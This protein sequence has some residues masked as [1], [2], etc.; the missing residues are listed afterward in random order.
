MSQ[1]V[2]RIDNPDNEQI[3]DAIIQRIE[4]VNVGSGQGEVTIVMPGEYDAFLLMGVPKECP[5]CLYDPEA[6][7]DG[8]FDVSSRNELMLGLPEAWQD[9]D[10]DTVTAIIDLI[11]ERGVGPQHRFMKTMKEGVEIFWITSVR[12]ICFFHSAKKVTE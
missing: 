9:M 3:L 6:P 10:T 8:K 5:A 1:R 12:M 7:L 2:L 4:M 11:I